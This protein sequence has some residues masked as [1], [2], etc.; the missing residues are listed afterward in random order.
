MIYTSIES[1]AEQI[2][3]DPSGKKMAKFMAEIVAQFKKSPG[4]F[5]MWMQAAM[6]TAIAL[7]R[8]D[9]WSDD[10]LKKIENAAIELMQ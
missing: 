5:S 3:D 1:I 6:D 8:G 4:E 7:E 10:F 2:C 9:E